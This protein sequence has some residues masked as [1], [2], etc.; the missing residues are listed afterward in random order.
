LRRTSVLATLLLMAVL[1]TGLTP[2][3]LPSSEDPADW[4]AALEMA[5]LTAGPPASGPWVRLRLAD[6][7]WLLQVR[8]RDGALHEV[9]VD[10]P[11][12]SEQ[13]EDLL[14]LAVSLLHPS[15]T[16]PPPEPKPEVRRSPPPITL[17]RDPEPEPEPVPE[18]LTPPPPPPP[19]EPEP[20]P[21]AEVVEPEPEPEPVAEVVEPEPEPVA[22]V[23][24]P[25]P[26]PVAEVVEPEPEPEPPLPEPEPEPEPVVATVRISPHELWPAE[27]P[28]MFGTIA[29]GIDGVIGASPTA[30][31]SLDLGVDLAGW[32]R[33]GGSAAVVGPSVLLYPDD[34][35][36]MYGGDLVP[37]AAW[38][39]PTPNRRML[40]IGAG[41]GV[42]FFEY[43]G[44]NG[45]GD[46]TTAWLRQLADDIG[47]STGAWS[48]TG[49]TDPGMDTAL[50]IRVEVQGAI[51]LAEWMALAPWLQLQT[52]ILSQKDVA[53]GRPDLLF[54]LAI[55]GGVAV[56][57]M[58]H[59]G[60]GLP[61]AGR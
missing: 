48:W 20:E 3:E 32:L 43:G 37:L 39:T 22:E 52:N 60:P 25:E 19:P 7:G 12:S 13:R 40:W 24:E 1:L 51:R 46:A 53:V 35:T 26:E 28:R 44:S 54:P 49:S 38:V 8:D 31:L 16:A 18:P 14:W 47:A 11:T 50:L 15:K 61:P 9:Q 55:R 4:E 27:R 21:V 17:D 34:A 10:A 29:L 23:V 41:V 56:V 5:G 59:V 6:A 42:R 57:L 33:L 58:R 45:T 36:L 2:V 30:S